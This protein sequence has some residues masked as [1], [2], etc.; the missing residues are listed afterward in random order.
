MSCLLA[1]ALLRAAV[2]KNRLQLASLCAHQRRTGMMQLT[3]QFQRS[4]ESTYSLSS[5]RCQR[6]SSRIA[7]WCTRGVTEAG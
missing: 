4:F 5:K 3:R 7:R 6:R 1:E 2:A